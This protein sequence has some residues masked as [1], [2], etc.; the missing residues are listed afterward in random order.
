VL[1]PRLWSRP[2]LA[3]AASLLTLALG[4]PAAW[5]A[6]WGAGAD[7][8]PLAAGTTTP[9][10]APARTAASGVVLSATGDAP[11]PPPSAS[12][13]TETAGM[14][15]DHAPQ[16]ALAAGPASAPVVATAAMHAAAASTPTGPAPGATAS[17]SASAPGTSASG[18]NQRLPTSSTLASADA[19]ASGPSGPAS[20][21]DAAARDGATGASQGGIRPGLSAEVREAARRESQA[22]RGA[23]AGASAVS[24]GGSAPGASSPTGQV[25]AVATPATRTRAGAQLRIVL[26]NAPTEADA[27]R[28]RAEVLQVAEGW[29]AVIWPYADRASAER[30]RELLAA[31]G[32]PAEVIAF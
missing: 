14:S 23:S 1:G 16:A 11:A 15:A 30:T 12:A 9:V 32:I 13:P 20:L 3:T 17:L 31:R 7:P 28:P 21:A 6:G 27:G 5:W 22:L 26:M 4:G 25:Y 8:A 10:A 29:R 18:S 2:R 19:A 24:S